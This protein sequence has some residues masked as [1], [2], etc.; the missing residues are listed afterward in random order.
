[1]LSLYYFYLFQDNSRLFNIARLTI[2]NETSLASNISR[3]LSEKVLSNDWLLICF[4]I[5]ISAIVCVSCSRNWI[6][7]KRI[8]FIYLAVVGCL[9]LQNKPRDDPF[10][11]RPTLFL[12][13][14]IFYFQTWTTAALTHVET[15][16]LALTA[17]TCTP[18]SALRGTRV[19][20]VKQ[21]RVAI[22]VYLSF[23]YS[24]LVQLCS[25]FTCYVD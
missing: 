21:V 23:I 10:H 11:F 20:S 6:F 2:I 9:Q 25:F 18:A 14:N 1:M 24:V 12:S 4:G 8:V 5:Y 16:A 15:E 17:S 7:G 3:N 22:L 19:R 13:D